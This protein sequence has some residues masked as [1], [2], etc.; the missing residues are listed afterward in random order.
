VD[1]AQVNVPAPLGNVVGV[2]DVVPELRPF[3]ADITNLCH[4]YSRWMIED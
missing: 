2:A 3:A 1:R 4:D